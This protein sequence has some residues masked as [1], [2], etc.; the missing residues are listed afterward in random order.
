MRIAP[1]FVLLAACD[2][3]PDEVTLQGTVFSDPGTTERLGGATL[4]SHVLDGGEHASTT[5]DDE[6]R[7]EL[8]APSNATV[9]V[10]VEAQGH[11]RSSFT[12]VTGIDGA[13]IVPDGT[14]YAITEATWDEWTSLFDGCPG[15]GEGGASIGEVRISNLSDPSTGER[16]FVTTAVVTLE[17][18][19]GETYE[20]C[21]L[22]E[23]GAAY[24]PE[25]EVTGAS[26]RFAIFGA[27]PGEY[28]LVVAYETAEGVWSGDHYPVRIT[29][30][31]VTPMFPLWTDFE[32]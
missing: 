32:L 7:F 2:G 17:D 31:G 14:M 16:P 1:L 9:F 6:G 5:A 25:A 4:T 13:M 26:G 23:E 30:G 3:I 20:A 24:D 8:L 10:D 12:G 29:E 19:E 22:D 27:P 28:L 11:V 18:S 21:Y 15:V